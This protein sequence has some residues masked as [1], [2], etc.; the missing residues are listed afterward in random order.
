M[1]LRQFFNR[2]VPIY[3]AGRSEY[4]EGAGRDHTV[5]VSPPRRVRVFTELCDGREISWQRVGKHWESPF[6]SESLSE[7]ERREILSKL[8]EYY[9][10]IGQKYRVLP[11][12]PDLTNR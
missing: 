12:S 5:F 11:D 9:D 4:F 1:T 6:E 8:C 7:A 10:L 2:I 3:R